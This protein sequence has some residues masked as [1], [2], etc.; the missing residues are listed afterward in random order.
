MRRV[1]SSSAEAIA[2]TRAILTII[3]GLAAL[4]CTGSISS[5][6]GQE[7]DGTDRERKR[8]TMVHNEQVRMDSN[9]LYACATSLVTA[10]GFAPIIGVLAWYAQNQK[11]A[12]EATFAILGVTI[13]GVIAVSLAAWFK[14]RARKLLSDLKATDRT[15]PR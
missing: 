13:F 4:V 6:A 1:S 7:A 11:K 14:H 5:S 9:F 2:L 15:S 12:N 8:Q 3:G 10:G